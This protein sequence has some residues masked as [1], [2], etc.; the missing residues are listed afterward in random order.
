MPARLFRVSRT[1]A[2]F[3]LL[4]W[5]DDGLDHTIFFLLATDEENTDTIKFPWCFKSGYS[6]KTNEN[7]QGTINSGSKYCL[8]WLTLY[9][10]LWITLWSSRLLSWCVRIKTFCRG[11]FFKFTTE[12]IFVIFKSMYFCLRWNGF[13]KSYY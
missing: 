9:F 8:L 11:F 12:W 3:K 2:W 10:S 1:C 13:K 4:I 6:P 5:Q 7:R